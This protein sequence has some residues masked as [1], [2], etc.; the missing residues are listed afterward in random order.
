M[1]LKRLEVSFQEFLFI[2]YRWISIFHCKLLFS[3]WADRFER[4]KRHSHCS[5]LLNYYYDSSSCLKYYFN[6]LK[7][8]NT[9][10]H[11]TSNCP[12]VYFTSERKK[13]KYCEAR[14]GERRRE[15]E[16]E[17]NIRTKVCP[18]NP[19]RSMTPVANGHW[20]ASQMPIKNHEFSIPL[21]SPSSSFLCLRHQYLPIV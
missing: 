3:T 18:G 4:I 12:L 16:E 17:G 20:L 15:R 11:F 14:E 2:S 10:S 1:K 13:E 7:L 19:T 6:P 5:T 21:F 9:F 8:T